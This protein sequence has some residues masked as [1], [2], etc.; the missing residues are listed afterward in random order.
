MFWHS[1][2]NKWALGG[3]Y[4]SAGIEPGEEE[5]RIAIRSGTDMLEAAREGLTARGF[6]F[7]G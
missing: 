4:P 3:R 2:L 7:E 6:D 1:D 5:A